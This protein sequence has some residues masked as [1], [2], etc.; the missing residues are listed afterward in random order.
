MHVCTCIHLNNS[1]RLPC[2]FSYV[3][4]PLKSVGNAKVLEAEAEK[5][6]RKRENNRTDCTVG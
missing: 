5:R 6:K 2:T 3:R 1:K 4:R